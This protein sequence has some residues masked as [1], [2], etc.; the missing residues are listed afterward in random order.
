MKLTCPCERVTLSLPDEKL[1]ASG[2]FLVG[3]PECG[4]RVRITRSPYGTKATFAEDP[5]SAAENGQPQTAPE[6]EIQ[7]AATLLPE[8]HET[9]EAPEAPPERFITPA[10]IPPGRI[11]AFLALADGAF[12]LAAKI[13]F[14]ESGHYLRRAGT[15]MAEAA[16]DLRVNGHE[17]CLIED[18]PDFAPLVAETLSWPGDRR[19]KTAVI[20]LGEYEDFDVKSAFY[21]GVDAVLNKS[22][23]AEAAK[24]LETAVQ[25]F[26]RRA[27]GRKQAS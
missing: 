2:R 22:D 5:A 9:P 24:R 3:C 20:L 18:T 8:V 4:K 27:R 19:K 25:N 14:R 6:V 21:K 1:P 12:S 13:F 15:D 10:P 17:L 26:R 11:S 7:D 23:S 16:A